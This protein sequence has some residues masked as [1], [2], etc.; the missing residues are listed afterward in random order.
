M[1][2][3]GHN[4]PPG[5]SS[6]RTGWWS[7]H[8]HERAEKVKLACRGVEGAVREERGRSE[9]GASA[10]CFPIGGKSQS[11]LLA[12]SAPSRGRSLELRGLRSSA[13]PTPARAS[14]RPVAELPSVSA[15]NPPAGRLCA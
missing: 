1:V 9:G 14:R 8:L 10:S 3:E 11:Q 12:L 15:A 13:P 4:G 5:F 7:L 2:G 6:G